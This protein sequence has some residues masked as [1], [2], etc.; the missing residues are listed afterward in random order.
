MSTKKILIADDSLIVL[1][2]LENKLQAAG[3]ETVTAA[4][5]SEALEQ[6]GREH[7]DLII[8]DVNFPPDISSGG[9]I[10]WDGFRIIEWIRHT[11][12]TGG[13]PSIMISA[14]D[15]EQ[16]QGPALKAGAAAI[17]QKPISVPALLETINECLEMAPHRQPVTMP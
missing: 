10:P 4:D 3:Y 5:S 9:G 8:M 2:A 11:G 16:H 17:F 12:A 7:P 1:K 14:D 15:I 6:A 13:A